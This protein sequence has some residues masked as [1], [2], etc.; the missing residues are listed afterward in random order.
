MTLAPSTFDLATLVEEVAEFP[1]A[2]VEEKHQRVVLTFAQ[3]PTVVA[4]R[5]SVRQALINVIHNAFRYGPAHSDIAIHLG[6]A[7]GTGNRRAIVEIRDQGPGIAPEYR[8]RIFE[9]FYRIDN[10]RARDRGGAG[11]GLPLHNGRSRLTVGALSCCRQ[12]A[13]APVFVSSCPVKGN[14]S[15]AAAV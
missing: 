1:R 3:R 2:L 6:L 15:V 8:E 7:D 5:P 10:D 14:K 13:R 12:R 11:P 4:D 9:R